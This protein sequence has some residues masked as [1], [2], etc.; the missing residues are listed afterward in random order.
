MSPGPSGLVLAAASSSSLLAVLKYVL[1]AVL[2]LFFIL[3]LRAVLTEVRR[4]GTSDQAVPREPV[5]TAARVPNAPR[6]PLRPDPAPAGS[7]SWAGS[8]GPMS[9]ARPAGSPGWAAAPVGSAAETVARPDW[10]SRANRQAPPVGALVLVE[11]VQD[12]GRS[13][14]V[15]DELTIGRSTRCGVSMPND[16]FISSVHARVWRQDGQVWVEDIGS[17]NGTLLNGNN[18]ARPSP[19]HPGDRLQV[20]KTVLE[21]A[22]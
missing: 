2:W 17:T 11:P 8:A 13:F 18:L 10:G 7:R 4:T 22:Q 12:R 6:P 3:V 14:P 9:A 20:G 15:G 16:S 5:P 21:A 19:I 1:L